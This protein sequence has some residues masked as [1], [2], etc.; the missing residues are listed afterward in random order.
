MKDPNDMRNSFQDSSSNDQNGISSSG[1]GYTDGPGFI[2]MDSTSGADSSYS[3]DNAYTDNNAYT[4]DGAYAADSN[5]GQEQ[6]D[7]SFSSDNGNMGKS[8]FLKRRHIKNGRKDGRSSGGITI[9]G[10]KAVVSMILVVCIAVAGGFSG[11][12]AYNHFFPTGSGG[13]SSGSIDGNNYTLSSATGSPKTIEEIVDAN[14][15]TVVQIRTQSVQ[16]DYWVGEYVTEGAGSGVIIKSNGTIVTNNHV[17]EGANE[18]TVT[19]HNGKEYSAEVLGTDSENDLAV[20]KID[21]SGL[22]AATYGNSDE[23]TVG[24]LSV[25][26]GNPLGELGGTVTAGVISS[27][28]RQITIDGQP[29]TLLQTDASINPGNSG[30]GMFDQYGHLVGIVV[31]K[32]SGSDVEG[33]GFA[34]PINRA[35]DIISQLIENGS[36]ESTSGYSGMTYMQSSSGDIVIAEVNESFAKEAGFRA[37]DIVLAIDDTMIDSMD[38]LTT[39]IK[40]HKKGDTVTYTIARQGKTM[41]ISL[42]LS[43]KN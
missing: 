41:Q 25:I 8:S 22:T 18:I 2:M 38:T 23:L 14:A 5:S 13:N 12:A 4:T 20:I 26:I 9:T 30:G 7:Y 16:S 34:I 10:K 1:S 39:A 27:L 35:A 32:S 19:L 42:Q 17:I 40:S 15:D 43:A 29:M 3:T 24:S 33:L 37:G 21:A 36:A 11:A 6:A 28:D 31:A